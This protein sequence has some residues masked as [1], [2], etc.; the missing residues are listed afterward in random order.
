MPLVDPVTMSA[1]APSATKKSLP[2]DLLPTDLSRTLAHAHPVLLL[3]AYYLRFPAL[4]TDPIHTLQ[5]SLLPLAIIQITYVF[6]CLPH[7]GSHA[8]PAKALKWKKRVHETATASKVYVQ[9]LI[10]SLSFKVPYNYRQ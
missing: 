6:C 8:K 10:L 9:P 7:A 1:P 2:I 3:A 5:H 4:V